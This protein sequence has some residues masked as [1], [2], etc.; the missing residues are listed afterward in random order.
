MYEFGQL[1]LKIMTKLQVVAFTHHTYLSSFSSL[2]YYF[3]KFSVFSLRAFKYDSFLCA[4]GHQDVQTAAESLNT[5]RTALKH[6]VL[7]A[8]VEPL[9]RLPLDAMRGSLFDLTTG[10]ISRYIL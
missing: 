7:L 5:G 10:R 1:S 6:Q 9:S 2:L 8:D 3:F 4:T